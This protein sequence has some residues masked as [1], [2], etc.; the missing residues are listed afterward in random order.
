MSNVTK[1]LHGT[2]M[3]AEVYVRNVMTFAH[4]TPE[5][6]VHKCYDCDVELEAG[7]QQHSYM[8]NT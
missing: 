3:V 4:L 6:S 1:Y 7:L 5:H 2:R 8:L